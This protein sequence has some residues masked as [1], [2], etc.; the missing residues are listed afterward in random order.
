MGM[1]C[2]TSVHSG[3]NEVC[4]GGGGGGG[5]GGGELY[6]TSLL[7]LKFTHKGH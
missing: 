4:G 3:H 6:M 7:D 5:R 1:A 2:E